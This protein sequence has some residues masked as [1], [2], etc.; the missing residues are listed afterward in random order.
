MIF[1]WP[2]YLVSVDVHEHKLPLGHPLLVGEVGV[3]S[4]KQVGE[5]LRPVGRRRAEPVGHKVHQVTKELHKDLPLLHVQSPQML[6]PPRCCSSR[7][8]PQSLTQVLKDVQT[9]HLSAAPESLSQGRLNCLL[10]S[11]MLQLGTA[12][13]WLEP[14][15]RH[16]LNDHFT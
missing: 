15:A 4:F 13:P 16:Y 6:P 5:G 10:Q 11:W 8:S 3:G 2:A 1:R 7:R 12:N 9:A 14:H